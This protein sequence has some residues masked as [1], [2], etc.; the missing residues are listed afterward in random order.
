MDDVEALRGTD[1]NPAI[2]VADEIADMRIQLARLTQMIQ[3][4]VKLETVSVEKRQS[5]VK[6]VS[7]KKLS[8]LIA[9]YQS[10]FRSH[11]FTSEMS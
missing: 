2:A 8:D 4:G 9:T 3:T 7:N 11:S 1:A 5:V 10:R 6:G